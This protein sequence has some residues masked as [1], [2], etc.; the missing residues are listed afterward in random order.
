[1]LASL[2]SSLPKASDRH[3][4]Y[5]RVTVEFDSCNTNLRLSTHPP[6]DTPRNRRLL[7][8]YG[9]TMQLGIGSASYFESMRSAT[10]FKIAFPLFKDYTTDHE[11]FLVTTSIVDPPRSRFFYH[12]EPPLAHKL[13]EFSCRLEGNTLAETDLLE[14]LPASPLVIDLSALT[15]PPIPHNAAHREREYY[16]V[17]SHLAALYYAQRLFTT[18]LQ[19]CALRDQLTVCQDDIASIH[20]VLKSP[21]PQITPGVLRQH[22]IRVNSHELAIFPYPIELPALLTELCEW[23]TLR[24][25]AHPVLFAADLF[26]NFTHL[27]PYGDGN[28][29][30]GRILFN[31]ALASSGYHPIPFALLER[32]S[33]Q[34]LVYKAQQ[35]GNRFKFYSLVFRELNAIS[36]M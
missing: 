32:D 13:T 25:S 20:S 5:F 29:R 31:M 30:L 22:P 28:G 26:L 10:D 36:A 35:L 27:H 18:R 3:R 12:I 7:D 11:Q 21:F 34:D 8:I 15:L 14:F 16:E 19:S 1:M 17:Y 24:V 23:T 33:Y 4:P 6:A 2:R 9:S